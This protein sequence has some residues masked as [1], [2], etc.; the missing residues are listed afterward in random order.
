MHE[1]K[2]LKKKGAPVNLSIT[3]TEMTSA[4]TDI[5]KQ[6]YDDVVFLNEALSTRLENARSDQQNLTAQLEEVKTT[7][8]MLCVYLCSYL[9]RSTSRRVRYRPQNCLQQQRIVII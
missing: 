8:G 6:E 1:A 4:D 5:V 2:Q 3:I 9:Q 7:L